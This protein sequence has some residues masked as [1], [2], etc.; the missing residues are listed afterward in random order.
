MKKRLFL[1][2]SDLSIFSSSWFFNS[3]SMLEPGNIDWT[4]INSSFSIYYI[5]LKSFV[6]NYFPVVYKTCRL[7]FICLSVSFDLFIIRQVT[8]RIQAKKIIEQNTRIENIFRQ[9]IKEKRKWDNNKEYSLIF[10][11]FVSSLFYTGFLFISSWF[12][13]K[14]IGFY[15]YFY[16]MS[17][18]QMIW[19]G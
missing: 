15:Y 12:V 19:R 7:F 14:L 1:Y 9:S 2:W 18:M 16:M 6:R 10:S 3:I 11:L 8:L 5:F 17:T 13:F 4:C